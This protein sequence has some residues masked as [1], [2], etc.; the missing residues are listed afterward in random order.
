MKQE[1][2]EKIHAI[3]HT[4]PTQQIL[5]VSDVMLDKYIWGDVGHISPEALVS[6]LSTTHQNVQPGGA[7][8][9]A[10]NLAHL[11]AR[12]SV[13]GFA[14][15]D[16]DGHHLEQ[17]FRAQ[18]IARQLIRIAG[19][20]T[21]SEL[22]VLSG[23]QQMLSIDSEST[24]ERCDSDFG[25]LL[26]AVLERL[27]SAAAVILSDYAKGALSR[28]VCHEI[29]QAAHSSQTSEETEPMRS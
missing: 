25:L 21:T 11:G 1:F 9:A 24:N 19:A 8:N 29:V 13:V 6:L 10:M 20:P 27:P 2:Q 16:E 28:E 7:A 14:G 17:C 3:E 12:D 23:R 22:R 15:D 26:Q 5:V 4:W 18:N